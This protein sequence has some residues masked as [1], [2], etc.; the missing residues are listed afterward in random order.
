MKVNTQNKLITFL[1]NL[2]KV[3][4]MKNSPIQLDHANA[5]PATP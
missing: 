4:F 2:I 1:V 3:D 5:L